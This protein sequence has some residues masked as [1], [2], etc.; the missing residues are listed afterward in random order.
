MT[1][2]VLIALLAT[3]LAGLSTMIGSTIAFF[4]KTT[5]RR[6]LSFSLGLSAGVMV[7]VSFA[8][9]LKKSQLLLEKYYS[10]LDANMYN[11][12]AFFSGV[13]LMLFIDRL[14]PDYENPHEIHLQEE[15][16]NGGAIAA[17]SQ[18]DLFQLRR[19]G[20]FMALAVG[21][22]NFPEGLVTFLS[23]LNEPY[24]GYFIAVAIAIHNI[25]EGISISVPIYYATE[26][27]KK[28][29]IYSSLSGLAE[30]IGALIGY[31]LLAPILTE[32]MLGLL[33]A[34]V[35]GV[36]VYISIDEL[37]PAAER[38]G[39]HHISI[40]GFICGMAIMAISLLL[41]MAG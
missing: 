7:Y 16:Q 37:L 22:H 15:F 9:I 38:Y 36:M 5:Q 13:L 24:T 26:S 39:E 25:P 14:I 41:L 12:L 4:F 10:A 23:V 33:F 2:N 40:Y 34:G 6:F 28:A 31:A 21:I 8:E 11:V 1:D 3:L 18:S 35:A 17:F 32:P 29:F 27:K 19:A 20:I 30:P